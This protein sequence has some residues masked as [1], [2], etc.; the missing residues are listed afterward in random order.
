[1]DSPTHLLLVEDEPDLRDALAEYLEASGFAVLVAG[2]AEEAYR[3]AQDHLPAGVLCDLSLPDARG[4][5][6]LEQFHT[7]YPACVLFVHSGDSS[8]VPSPQLK[9]VG[10][11]PEHVFS[12]PADLSLLT[13]CLWAALR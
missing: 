11:V 10:L 6:F 8:F 7:K 12:K 5:V 1:M 4:D 2:N 13:K 9:A 3:A